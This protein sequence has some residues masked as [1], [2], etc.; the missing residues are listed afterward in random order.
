[1][2]VCKVSNHN[3]W[4]GPLGNGFNM[5]IMDGMILWSYE[6]KCVE[7]IDHGHGYLYSPELDGGVGVDSLFEIS[8]KFIDGEMYV[9]DEVL[10]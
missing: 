2:S 3:M 1:M 10:L 8:H 7:W 4:K 5:E 6:G 9:L